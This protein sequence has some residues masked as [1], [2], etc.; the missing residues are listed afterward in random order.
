MRSF[1]RVKPARAILTARHLPTL[2]GFAL[3][4]VLLAFEYEGVL[5]PRPGADRIRM[6]SATRR[7]LTRVARRYPTVVI[8][9]SSRDDLEARLNGVPVWDVFGSRPAL[10]G[11]RHRLGR[12]RTTA[13][14]RALHQFACDTAIYVGQH[15]P[16]A[17]LSVGDPERLLGIV[18]GPGRR[19]RPAYQLESQARVD[20]LLEI[21]LH[22][23]PVAPMRRMRVRRQSTDL[24]FGN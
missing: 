22:L 12:L 5:A 20:E 4:N 14:R 7:L 16:D 19:S 6:R 10:D 24:S 15:V 17:A 8:S 23:R 1:A 18:V 11:V 21:L 3:S 2:G 13:L 9:G